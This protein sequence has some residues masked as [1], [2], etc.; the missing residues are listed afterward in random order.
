MRPPPVRKLPW[1]GWPLLLITLPL[2]VAAT[3]LGLAL[4]PIGW[5]LGAKHRRQMRAWASE[6]SGESICTF[7]RG[8]DVRSTD[9]WVLRAVY[10][11]LSRY[12]RLDGR[13]F[14]IHPGDRWE[15]DLAIDAEDLTEDLLPDIAHRAGRC[16]RDTGTNP[17][18]DRVKTVRDLVGFLEHQPRLQGVERGACT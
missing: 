2:L 6:R 10:E 17:Y 15:E 12:L 4:F 13:P 1:W 5:L 14:P 7:V 18:Y 3:V 8:F 11:E 16:L 9:A